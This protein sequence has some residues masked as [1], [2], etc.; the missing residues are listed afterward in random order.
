MGTIKH[1]KWVNEIILEK[2]PPF[3]WVPRGY[4]VA[5]QLLIMEII[6]LSVAALFSLSTRS[7]LYGSLAILIV[8]IWSLL[9]FYIASTV[10]RLKPPSAP[11]ERDV[12]NEYQKSLFSPRHRELG[13]ALLILVFILVYLLLEHNLVVLWLDGN[14]SPI[15]LLLVVLLL[16][17]ISYRLGLGLW[18]SILAFRRSVNLFQVSKKRSKMRYTAYQELRTLKRLD[19]INLSFGAVTLLFYPLAS[20]DLVFFGG[21]LIYSVGISFFS[22]ISYI[23]IGRV[24]GFPQEVIW[25]LTEGKFGYVGTSDDAMIPHLTPVIFVFD[26]HRIFFVVSKI[27]KK[28]RNM[29]VNKKISFLVDMR[30]PNNLYNNRAIL[31]MGKARVYG[32]LDAALNILRLLKVRSMFYEKYP[33]YVHKYKT[34]GNLLPLAW[35]TTLFISRIIVGV[36]AEQMIYWRQ[37]RPIRLPLR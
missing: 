36:E 8:W 16:W 26:G 20:T 3:S 19:L 14:L 25:L 1:K 30:D 12:I 27:S 5:L 9:A 24:P 21:L 33:E 4:N 6:G 2:V 7:M 15:L 22:A 10:H 11:S 18:S 31:F 37:A 17:E 29:R 35:R 23:T 32:L 34:E 13:F 28:L